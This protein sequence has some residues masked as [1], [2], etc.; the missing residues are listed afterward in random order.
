MSEPPFDYSPR[1]RFPPQFYGMVGALVSCCGTIERAMFDALNHYRSQGIEVGQISLEFKRRNNQW[2]Q[3]VLADL[4]QAPDEVLSVPR[5]LHKSTSAMFNFRHIL[6]HSRWMGEDEAGTVWVSLI[7]QKG[8]RSI[9]L[10]VPIPMQHFARNLQVSHRL[11]SQH[12]KFLV[13]VVLR[14]PP[15]RARE[16]YRPVD[17]DPNGPTH[18]RQSGRP[19]RPEEDWKKYPRR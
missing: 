9:E 18:P 8:E 4:G 14:I 16:F 12:I 17:V 5:N 15:E 2:L 11:A 6:V 10:D 7:K 19:Y 1:G 3:H 13:E